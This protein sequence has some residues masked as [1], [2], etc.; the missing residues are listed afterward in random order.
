MQEV[1]P[2]IDDLP[3]WHSS[4][5]LSDE[6]VHGDFMYL[7]TP[8]EVQTVHPTD[9]NKLNFLESH[10]E[11]EDCPPIEYLPAGQISTPLRSEF[12]I[13]PA[14]ATLQNDA[15]AIEYLPSLLQGKHPIKELAPD[16]EN[17]A[18]GHLLQDE[19]PS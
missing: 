13:N 18:I 8:H 3:T 7:P 9:P 17:V 11:H 19:T 16:I 12:G 5:T 14:P 6:R 4:H 15:P 10:V 1:D 2:P